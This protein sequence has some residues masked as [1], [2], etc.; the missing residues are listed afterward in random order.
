MRGFDN[1]TLGVLILL[2][3]QLG[4]VLFYINKAR[5]YGKL[6]VRRIPGIDAIDEAIGRSAELGRPISFS[7]GLTVVSPVLYACLGVLHH[8]A[9]K[10]AHYKSRLLLPQNNPEVMA[11]AEDVLRDSY[12]SV[13]K[14]SL[15]DPRS[16][17]FLSEEQF[18]YA[19]GYI[20]LIQRERVAAAFLF[21]NFAAESLILA[22]AGQQIGA[23][24]VGATISPEQVA[25]FIVSCDYTLIGEELFAAS[26]YL[27]REP[28]QLGSLCGQDAAKLV[29]FVLI[30]LGTIVATLQSFWPA[31]GLINLDYLL[32][33]KLW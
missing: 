23:M 15:F 21:G 33:Y 28:I 19:A 22:E 3:L 18:A 12:R 17:I 16:I 11:I 2:P 5:K 24:Q 6:Y 30:I 10:A 29:L 4:P 1:A 25:F 14:I 32:Y 27:T 31:A 8:V 13:G 9:C 26:A 7:T 20:G